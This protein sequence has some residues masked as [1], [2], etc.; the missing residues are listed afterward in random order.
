VKNR[1]KSSMDRFV[2]VNLRSR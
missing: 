1:N 2:W